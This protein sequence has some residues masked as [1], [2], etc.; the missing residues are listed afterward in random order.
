[1]VLMGGSPCV[2]AERKGLEELSIRGIQLRRTA[3]GV[4]GS[5]GRQS[6]CGGG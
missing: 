5:N 1:M 2:E 3:G 6:V 4:Y